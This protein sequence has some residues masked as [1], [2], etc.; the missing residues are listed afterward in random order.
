M[1]ARLLDLI[2]SVIV[3]RLVWHYLVL[4]ENEKQKQIQIA[5][6]CITVAFEK[7]H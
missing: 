4:Y 5:S 6:R 7:E 2:S 3:N 1:R